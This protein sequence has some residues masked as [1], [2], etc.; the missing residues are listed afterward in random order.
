MR[1][2]L[3]CRCQ[4][5]TGR[6]STLLPVLKCQF[7]LTWKLG[8]LEL[9]MHKHQFTGKEKTGNRTRKLHDIYPAS[10]CR[11]CYKSIA[12]CSVRTSSACYLRDILHLHWFKNSLRI[13]LW[14]FTPALLRFILINQGFKVGAHM[15]VLPRYARNKWPFGE[16]QIVSRDTL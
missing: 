6:F 1:I 16:K 13:K 12:H 2:S 14:N 3:C 7:I 4:A 11:D 5:S 15:E 8:H 10:C 9:D